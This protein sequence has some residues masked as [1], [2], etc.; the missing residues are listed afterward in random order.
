MFITLADTF[1]NAF[2]WVE[3]DLWGGEARVGNYTFSTFSPTPHAFLVIT[4]TAS[5]RQL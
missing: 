3:C 5:P 4:L 2:L 1:N